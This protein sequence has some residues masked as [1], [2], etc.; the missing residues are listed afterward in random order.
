MK[1]QLFVNVMTKGGTVKFHREYDFIK[2][3]RNV[4]MKMALNDVMDFMDEKNIHDEDCIVSLNFTE[5]GKNAAEQ[6][7]QDK[8][9]NHL[10]DISDADKVRRN[11]PDNEEVKRSE[12]HTSE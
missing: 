10:I 11:F 1:Q 4:M 2:R 3:G 5:T 12:E 9:Y 6:R 8:I 7:E